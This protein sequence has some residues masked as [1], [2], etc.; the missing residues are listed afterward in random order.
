MRFSA[1]SLLPLS[2]VPLACGGEDVPPPGLAN[3]G[4]MQP[5]ATPGPGGTTVVIPTS[6]TS[7]SPDVIVGDE[8]VGDPGP[9]GPA[10]LGC[11]DG[12]LTT[13]EACD[14]HNMADGDGC[15]ANCLSVERGFSCAAPGAPCLPIALC[16]DGLVALSEQCDD[17]A[18]V[19]GDGCS[20]RCKIEKGMKCEGTPS[21]CTPATCG[22]GVQEGAE[23]CDD[24]NLT[25]FDGCSDTCE[26]EP[27]CVVGSAT[28]C[29]SACGDGL[30]INEGCDDGNQIDGDGCSSLCVP[31]Q[32]FT[33]TEV[34]PPCEQ[35]GAECI[36]RVPVVYR[37]H[38]ED[39]PDFGPIA[40]ECSRTVT[41]TG[42]IVP[43]NVLTKG[44]VQPQL[45]AEGRPQLVGASGTQDCESDADK[46]SYTGITQ[47][48]DWFRNGDHVVVAPRTLVMFENG[49]GGYVNR[50]TEDG[51]QFQGYESETGDGNGDFTCSWCL[52]GD[53]ADK[54]IGDEVL[55]DGSPLF[56]P[57]DDITGPTADMGPA[58]VP[59]EYGYTAWPWEE[60]LFGSADDHNFYFTT[61]VQTWFKYEATT[62]ATLEF[63]G[64]DDVWVYVNGTL[65]VDLGGIHVPEDGS[66]T[67]NAA[68]AT[69]YGLT[70]GN[71][72]QL[73]VFQAERRMEGSSFRLTLSGFEHA[74]SE[75]SAVCGDGV[76]SFGEEC[77]DVVNDGGY[78]ECSA[79]CTLG[80]F[81]GDGV[82]SGPEQCDTGAVST[83]SCS[84]CRYLT[85]R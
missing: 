42:E 78:G 47:F 32:G 55:F 16:G 10:P 57:I 23:S 13:D 74:P 17:G 59:A 66:V 12:T 81:C 51:E 36:L 75:C 24:A 63:T 71:V 2:F 76:V 1:L 83:G 52:D 65:A 56:F 67:I 34:I 46:A 21:V 3:P 62:D 30:V 50:F 20:D 60:D 33:C 61:E 11:G 73:S 35:L 84:G 18:K 68:S 26:R 37:D 79:N 9:T 41:E 25:P 54:C 69:K 80:E 70:V 6:P 58:K 31:E 39:H 40:G 85:V 8:P 29:T 82:V 44:L 19:A 53:C 15:A 43:A 27:T 72:Y 48:G 5:G 64:D 28:G 4:V 14:D 38:S 77:D 49:M 45:D 22:D 7:G